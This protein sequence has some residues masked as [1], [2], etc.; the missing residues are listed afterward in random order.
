MTLRFVVAAA[1]LVVVG[2]ACTGD[3]GMGPPQ[4]SVAVVPATSSVRI[5][6]SLQ[7]S[8]TLVDGEGNPLPTSGATW[9]SSDSRVVQVSADGL[10]SGVSI[11][12]PVTIT[13]TVGTSSGRA[14]INVTAGPPTQLTI[15]T[16]PDVSA[17]SGVALSRQPVLQLRDEDGNASPVAGVSV[18]AV[19][20][21]GQGS[22]DNGTAV[23][24]AQGRA[25]FSGLTLSGTAGTHLIR[26]ESDGLTDVTS[27]AVTLGAGPP[28]SVTIDVAPP[29]VIQ[30]GEP[31]STQPQVI[32]LDA[33][34]NRVA[35]TSVVAMMASG[36]G[37]LGGT[38]T[39][40][41][42]GMG[43][44]VFSDLEVSGPV[45]DVTLTFAAGSASAETDT[46][47][48]E[49]G[50][51]A[52]V[53]VSTE[54]SP[55]AQSG[56]VFDQ[57]PVVQVRDDA[58]NPTPGLE[59]EATIASGGG[60]LGGTLTAVTNADG[61]AVFADLSIV[62]AAGPRT[63]RFEADGISV[64]SEVVDLM[65]GEPAQVT[66][67]VQPSGTVQSGVVFP[68]QPVVEVADNGGNVVVGVD[69][70]VTIASGGGTLSG[71]ATVT[72]DGAGLATFSGLSISGPVGPRTLQFTVGSAQATSAS[73]EVEPGPLASLAITQQPSSTAANDEPFPQ[74]PEVTAMDASGN[75][76]AG[77][78]VTAGIASGG[79]NL[80][81]TT[82]VDTDASG[83]AG[84]SN[85]KITGTVG[86][87]T[88][89]FYNGATSVTSGSI[90]VVAGA[91]QTVT[92]SQQPPASAIDGVTFAQSPIV[93][94]ADVSGNPVPSVDVV[95]TI[96]SGSGSL[97]GTTTVATT[98]GGS[99]TFSTLSLTG[100]PGERT[101][102][103]TSEGIQSV[104]SAVHLSLSAG[105]YLDLQYCGSDPLQRLDVYVPD[106][107]FPRPRPVVAYV[108]GGSWTG[109]DKSEEDLV[110]W[111][112]VRAE[113]L[114]RGY[115]VTTLNYRLATSDPSTKWPAQIHDLKCAV[116][117][118]RADGADYGVDGD[119][120]GVWGASAGGHL[121][122]MLGV[123]DG[124]SP[125][126]HDF[127]GTLGYGGVSSA[128]Q[129]TIPI[130]GISD[131]TFTQAPNHDELNFIGGSTAFNSWPGPSNE[132]D[133][134]SP[135]WW[136]SSDDPPFLII[137]GEED[138][139][140]DVAQ[141]Q[142]LFDYLDTAGAGVVELQ[143]VVNAGHDLQDVTGPAMPSVS[144][145]VQQVSDF[146]D[147]HIGNAP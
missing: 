9:T 48:L 136:A 34:G 125:T 87:R 4:T 10:V 39:V 60:T 20:A 25:T 15:E 139:T 124:V 7:L 134:A 89:R 120:I 96:E 126:V 86:T 71:T 53:V 92:I 90:D 113:L 52:S 122:A 95:A 97:N 30:S 73:I 98:T 66:V 76:I 116:R 37:T 22:L 107:S 142:R 79:G 110:L 140:V 146:F 101:L 21:Q 131:M 27:E 115:V 62:G 91:P 141:G 19:V 83:A 50:S 114:S 128:V 28:A 68:Q 47:A 72:T 108:H 145:L 84:F 16:Q 133:E 123:T 138:A 33:A 129:A 67:V 93:A 40:T 8:A 31:F 24:D 38:T 80:G 65:A 117:H 130:G 88:L 57:Q 1:A 106:N 64:V 85:L 132:L 118:L 77:V 69:V 100:S 18:A 51:S 42:D 119:R 44:A 59:V 13:A 103:F 32:V 105:T 70:T 109:H 56:V 17:Q 81:G 135:I 112:N 137:H 11:G 41:A 45:G 46:L 143:R 147:T 82:V 75:G 29:A 58:G 102:R 54:P 5:G 63:L 111:A 43:V 78:S 23:T 49:A 121:V 99:A 6:E 36:Q 94:V 55:I 2:L 104:S 35:G 127:E 74:Q 26:F 61:Q 3:G 144:Q 14:S 12:G